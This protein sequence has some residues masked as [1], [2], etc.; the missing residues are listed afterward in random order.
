MKKLPI[1]LFICLGL[2]GSISADTSDGWDKYQKGNFI[3]GKEDGKMT[4]WN[5]D[6]T[7]SS[8]VIYKDGEC[9]SGD[10]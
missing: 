5:E 9:I 4:S 8:E 2:I 3:D 7:I 10:C 6:G 1:I